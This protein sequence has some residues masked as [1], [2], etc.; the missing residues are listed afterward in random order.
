MKSLLKYKC[1]THLLLCFSGLR[2]LFEFYSIHL[3]PVH[4]TSFSN[5]SVFIDIQ[6]LFPLLC[7]CTKTDR[8]IPVFVRSHYPQ[9]RLIS[10]FIPHCSWF[11]FNYVTL[12]LLA[13]LSIQIKNN[14][15]ILNMTP[16]S[17]HS[18][19]VE[20]WPTRWQRLHFTPAIR[21]KVLLLNH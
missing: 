17:E 11:I 5:L 12:Y 19:L 14:L 16:F 1:R 3:R 8:K 18:F 9:K 15:L 4:T 7:F 21:T 2:W 10:F 13:I 6:Y 20:H